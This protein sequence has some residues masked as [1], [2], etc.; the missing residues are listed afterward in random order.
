MNISEMSDSREVYE[1]KPNPII[2]IFL[3]TILGIV[4]VAFIWMYFGK[5]DVV[6]KSEAILRPNDQVAT[7]I[8]TYAGTLEIV[9]IEMVPLYK[10]AMYFIL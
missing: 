1:S 5:I 2:A 6:V 7:V 8:N 9:N 4:V 3:Y 10:R